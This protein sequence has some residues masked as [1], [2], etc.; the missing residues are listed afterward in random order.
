MK[1]HLFKSLAI[2]FAMVSLAFFTSCSEEE[3]ASISV[4]SIAVNPP[5]LSLVKGGET[6][7]LDVIFKPENVK[8]KDVVWTSS[9]KTVAT[10][11]VTGVVT[12]IKVGQTTIKA[13]SVSGSK[14]G[15]CIVT[16]TSDIIS[17]VGITIKPTTLSMVKGG[18]TASLAVTFTPENATNK[19]VIWSTSD[20]TVAD[21]GAS[22]AIV[23]RGVGEATITATTEDGAKIATCTVKVSDQI[24]SVNGVS[25]NPSTLKLFEKGDAV[26]LTTTFTPQYVTNNN[27]TWTSSDTTVAT[28]DESGAVTPV[29]IGNTV[30]TVITED[31]EKRAT[32][33]V[34]VVGYTVVGLSG[35]GYVTEMRNGARITSSGLNYWTN[36]ESVISTY[37]YLH[38][39]GNFELALKAKGQSGINV[40]CNNTTYKVNINSD[41][42][43]SINIGKFTTKNPGYVRVD[44]QGVETAISNFGQVEAILVGTKSDMSYVHD[45]DDYWGRRGPSV[46]MGYEL[47]T[48]DTEWFYNEVTVPKDGETM[49]S[50]YMAA[51]FGE[52]YFGMQYNSDTERRILFSVWSQFV[53]D[54]PSTIPEEDRIVLKKRGRDVYIGEFGNEGSG[55]QSYLRYNWTAGETYKFLMK[56]HP[57]GNGNTIYTA[58]F[59]AT[60]DNE[61]RLIASFM[62]PKTDTWYKNPHSFLE[63]FSPDQGYLSREVEFSNQWACSKDGEWTRLNKGHFTHD[64]TASAGVRLDYQGGLLDN[65]SF[66]LKMGGF[67][68][69]STKANTSFTS[70]YTGEQPDIDFDYLETI[71]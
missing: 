13:V 32:C 39:A 5:T 23:P 50:Y 61:W 65:G 30:I 54:D 63:N 51:G 44:L 22:G 31:G 2:M 29:K 11:S 69:K 33:D 18:K 40:T 24:I 60:D 45:F 19:K 10:V 66:Y 71:N 25:I 28:I 7:T 27:V 62:R 34:N 20:K 9:D 37:F 17:V 70:T 6:A 16:V 59:F 68:N 42:F 3:T 38:E 46:H 41:D 36:A 55:G 15:T 57:D 35:N 52:G 12:P 14:E 49:H 53:T 56:V 8:N 4:T 47:P 67:F 43:S 58:F 21:V 1:T 64:A 48:G 26:T